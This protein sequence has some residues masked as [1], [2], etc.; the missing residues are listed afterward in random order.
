[1]RRGPLRHR[2]RLRQ[3][4]RAASPVGASSIPHGSGV[5]GTPTGVRGP[6][7]DPCGTRCPGQVSPCRR[8]MHANGPSPRGGPLRSTWRLRRIRGCGTPAQGLEPR[9]PAS[10]G[11][12]HGLPPK[13]A[14][15]DLPTRIAPWRRRPDRRDRRFR[16]ARLPRRLASRRFL[17]Q[18]R[19]RR[20]AQADLQVV[21]RSLAAPRT[22]AG[23]SPSTTRSPAW[24]AGP[25]PVRLAAAWSPRPI[26]DDC[27]PVLRAGQVHERARRRRGGR[28]AAACFPAPPPPSPTTARPAAAA[29]RQAPA[30]GAT[31]LAARQVALRRPVPHRLPPAGGPWQPHGPAVDA[32]SRSGHDKSVL[33]RDRWASSSV[34]GLVGPGEIYGPLLQRASEVAD[35]LTTIVDAVI[36]QFTADMMTVTFG[37]PTPDQPPA[38]GEDPRNPPL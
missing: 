1:M 22:R 31:G 23:R 27:R 9:V 16:R 21:N 13:S 17:D 14:N 26:R 2:A 34:A 32:A 4:R 28:V 30:F 7:G 24:T 37:P 3:R 33:V 25:G 6:R 19:P 35:T 10:V 18:R 5:L 29:G 12:T 38:D 8:A 20:P 11:R 15:R 36:P